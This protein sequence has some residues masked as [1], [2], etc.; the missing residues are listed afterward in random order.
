MK[1]STGV[2]RLVA[3]ALV[4]AAGGTGCITSMASST[5]RYAYLN[6]DGVKAYRSTASTTANAVERTLKEM[7][8]RL[9]EGK[10]DGLNVSIAGKTDGNKDVLIE[11][12]TLGQGST[13]DIRN[14]HFDGEAGT[15]Q[16]FNIFHK[17]LGLQPME[18]EDAME[19][20]T[21]GDGEE[22]PKQ[23]QRRKDA[24]RDGPPPVLID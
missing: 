9:T 19:M 17:H 16:F 23:Y 15:E 10:A 1:V 4:A 20:A 22:T 11:V 2:V 12:R 13:I 8:V 7:N 21:V 5:M 24:Q 14:A 6:R 18:I 3:A